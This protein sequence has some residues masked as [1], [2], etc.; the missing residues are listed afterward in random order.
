[1]KCP[2]CNAENDESA[3]FCGECGKRLKENTKEQYQDDSLW[4]ENMTFSWKP[5]E[6]QQKRQFNENSEQNIYQNNYRPMEPQPRNNN[7]FL[8]VIIGVC[9]TVI[10]FLSAVVG[11]SIIKNKDED[12]NINTQA[13]ANVV[14]EDTEDTVKDSQSGAEEDADG[15]TESTEQENA[16]VLPDTDNTFA[17]VNACLSPDAYDYAESKDGSYGF[18]YPKYLFNQYSIDDTGTKYHLSY[19]EDGEVLYDLYYYVEETSG[20]PLDSVSKLQSNYMSRISSFP[21][22]YHPIKQRTDDFAWMIVAGAV[23]GES[24][25][26]LYTVAS[27][28]GSRNYVMEFD[29]YDPDPSYDYDNI[30]YVIDCL[31]RGFTRS[32]ST[33][34]MRS[35]DYW[36]NDIMGDKK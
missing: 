20:D 7:A 29:H 5:E 22:P 25:R 35:Y 31:Y 9:L 11:V 27:S 19:E 34:Q 15:E 3:V 17:D 30:D 12:S 24:N 8:Y 6:G 2:Y 26:C 13:S 16:S 21:E 14:T 32:G 33:Y 10:V 18:Y 36:K 4:T 28:D 1:M 23:S